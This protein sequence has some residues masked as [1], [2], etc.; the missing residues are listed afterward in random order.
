MVAGMFGLI[1]AYAA[2]SSL[3]RRTSIVF[4]VFVAAGFGIVIWLAIYR[5]AQHLE[6]KKSSNKDK[7]DQQSSNKDKKDQQ[8]S[9]KDKDK[10]DDVEGQDKNQDEA[11][12]NKLVIEDKDSV[13]GQNM[14]YYLMLVG[15]LAASITY[16]TGLKPPGGMW[17]EDGDGHSAGNPVLYDINKRRYN[18]FFYSNS[19]SFVASIIVIAL[20]LS[21][22]MLPVPEADNFIKSL[23]QALTSLRRVHTA[24]VLDVLALLVAYAAG[25]SRESRRSWKVIMLFPIEVLVVLLFCFISIIR[26]A[27]FLKPKT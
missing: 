10:D 20:L 1:G 24:I 27:Y 25:S 23:L 17:K 26:K 11:S 19:A 15:I 9:N 16:L 7:K 14:A 4:L 18:V 2:G 22:M 13:K 3:H 6:K 8:S 21:R 12:S 5:Y